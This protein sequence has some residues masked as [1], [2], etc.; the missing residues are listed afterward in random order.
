LNKNKKAEW[1]KC[2]DAGG[3]ASFEGDFDQWEND[4][5]DFSGL[6]LDL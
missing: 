2:V 6:N 4:Y 5:M 1:Q 3:T